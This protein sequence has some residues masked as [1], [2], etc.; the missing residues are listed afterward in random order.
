MSVGLIELRGVT[1]R[2]GSG[3]AELLALKGID[4]DLAAGEF[5]AVMGPSGSGKPTAMNIPGC[6]DTRSAGQHLFKDADVEALSRERCARLLRRFLDFVF[7]GFNLLA[8]T[9]ALESGELPLLCRGDAAGTR[10]IA[11]MKAL[12]S[13]GLGGSEDHAPAE[14]SAVQQ[15]RGVIARAIVSER[16]VVLAEEPTATSMPSAATRSWACCRR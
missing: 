6:L 15:Q 13:V 1:K 7:Q 11:A 14:L 4:L 5:V 10:K 9:S 2:C 3:E 12:H 16:A 8:R